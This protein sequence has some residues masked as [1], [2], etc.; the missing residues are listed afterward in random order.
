MAL[1]RR[2][3]AQLLTSLAAR[4]HLDHQPERIRWYLDNQLYSTVTPDGR[5]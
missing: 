5:S 4:H 2:L 3:V 1:R